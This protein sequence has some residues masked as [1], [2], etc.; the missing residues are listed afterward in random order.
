MRAGLTYDQVAAYIE[1]RVAATGNL[2]T[3]RQ[4]IDE[5][6]GSATTVSRH[7][8]RYVELQA[9]GQPTELPADFEGGIAAAARSLAV[10]LWDQAQERIAA[11]ERALG[12]L[13]AEIDADAEARIADAD[14]Q[15]AE[16]RAA[17]KEVK[18]ALDAERQAAAEIRAVLKVEEARRRRGPWR[19]VRGSQDPRRRSRRYGPLKWQAPAAVDAD[20]DVDLAAVVAAD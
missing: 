18:S 17:L 7:R 11:R 8:Q 14:R 3:I 1:A 5:L 6:G 4:I 9:S 12:E 16:A 10:R 20:P 15:A 13:Q 2:P 19:V